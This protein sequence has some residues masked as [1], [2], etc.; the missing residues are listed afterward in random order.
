V[1]DGASYCHFGALLPDEFGWLGCRSFHPLP[2][3][4]RLRGASLL[5]PIIALLTMTLYR[6][7]TKA[8]KASGCE[9]CELLELIRLPK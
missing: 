2:R 5:L 9:G 6:R 7:P 4:A 1:R 8:V 3:L